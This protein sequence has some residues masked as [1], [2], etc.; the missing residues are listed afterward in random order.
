MMVSFYSINFPAL[1]S[2]LIL[3]CVAI[4][5]LWKGR[6]QEFTT[7]V[8]PSTSQFSI[9][10]TGISIRNEGDLSINTSM[11]F[12]HILCNDLYVGPNAVLQGISIT[13]RRIVNDGDIRS[14]HQI[15]AHTE[16]VNRKLLSAY[17]AHAARLVLEKKSLT[18]IQIVPKETEIVR[19]RDSQS[20]GFFSSAE[21]MNQHK[22]GEPRARPSV[23][24]V[25][26]LKRGS[27]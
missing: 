23:A 14:V 26:M 16:I 13:A 19:K 27:H 18:V 15:V 12:E 8:L 6:K 3:V 9:T 21:E 22:H 5:H 25:H 20:R 4:Y 7:S 1:V 11:K 10:E 2:L 24:S 17:Q